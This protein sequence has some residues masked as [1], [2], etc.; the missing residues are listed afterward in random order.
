[1]CLCAPSCG[2]LPV[3]A[4]PTPLTALTL[5]L[6][7][8]HATHRPR[9]AAHRL[10]QRHHELQGLRRHGHAQHWGPHVLASTA[11]VQRTGASGRQRGS[12]PPGRG[13]TQGGGGVPDT[14]GSRERAGRRSADVKA[15]FSRGRRA[16]GRRAGPRREQGQGG[17][18]GSTAH[19]TCCSKVVQVRA[20][21]LSSPTPVHTHKRA[22]L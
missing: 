18:Y 19:V 5:Y 17:R 10:P 22:A 21:P 9:A 7:A 12:V 15:I 1:M 6:R 8:R 4:F 11:A 2:S 13:G 14:T 3:S 20:L 16:P